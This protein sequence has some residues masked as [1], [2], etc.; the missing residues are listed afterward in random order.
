MENS[1]SRGSPK[2]RNVDEIPASQRLLDRRQ[3]IMGARENVSPEL[4]PGEKGFCFRNVH[5]Y[6]TER[7]LF[8]NENF[9]QGVEHENGAGA[10][11]T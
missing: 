7:H 4:V 8:A 6:G 2:L 9:S 3:P 10:R 11:R 5:I 1:T